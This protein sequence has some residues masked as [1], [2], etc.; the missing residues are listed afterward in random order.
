MHI[1]SSPKEINDS[2][3]DS[4]NIGHVRLTAM[5]RGGGCVPYT[6]SRRAA[7]RDN[8]LSNATGTSSVDL[9][10]RAASMDGSSLV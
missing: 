1:I 9:P 4:K 3:N 7:A 2:K 5:I 8:T 10:A 6:L